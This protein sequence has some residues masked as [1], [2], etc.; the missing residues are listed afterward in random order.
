MP[1]A[2][3]VGGQVA[4]GEGRLWQRAARSLGVPRAAHEEN[5]LLGPE[6]CPAAPLSPPPTH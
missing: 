3:K 2:G 1:Q 4:L 5:L 6:G